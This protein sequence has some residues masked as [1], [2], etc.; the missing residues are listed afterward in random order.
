MKKRV[1]FDSSRLEEQ[2]LA[3]G[4]DILDV[5]AKLNSQLD[6]HIAVKGK[7]FDDS[8]LEE[9]FQKMVISTS[10]VVRLADEWFDLRQEDVLIGLI[11]PLSKKVRTSVLNYVPATKACFAN[12][13][14]YLTKNV[15]IQAF[16]M[17]DKYTRGLCAIVEILHRKRL[18]NSGLSFGSIDSMDTECILLIKIA[19]NLTTESRHIITLALEGDPMEILTSSESFLRAMDDFLDNISQYNLS[20]V[21]DQAKLLRAQHQAIISLSKDANSANDGSGQ[22]CIEDVGEKGA[23]ISQQVVDCTIELILYVIMYFQK[24]WQDLIDQQTS[25]ESTNEDSEP[26]SLGPRKPQKPARTKSGKDLKTSISHNR[27]KTRSVRL[28]YERK[29]GLQPSYMDTSAPI[30]IGG[31]AVTPK[32]TRTP[33][34]PVASIR[35]SGSMDEELATLPSR[36]NTVSSS[37]AYTHSAPEKKSPSSKKRRSEPAVQRSPGPI[38]NVQSKKRR[39]KRKS[40]TLRLRSTSD[41]KK[42]SAPSSPSDC[43]AVKYVEAPDEA[44]QKLNEL[45]DHPEQFLEKNKT[46]A[47]PT[48]HDDAEC[49]PNL[50]RG[51]GKKRRA[52]GKSLPSVPA[53]DMQYLRSAPSRTNSGSRGVPVFVSG[54]FY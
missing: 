29:Y 42:D 23:D 27:A 19:N 1:T 44:E 54:F 34:L 45:F 21:K 10:T 17:V 8:S 36:A 22:L 2:L 31:S 18:R 6:V 26:N 50:K 5:S 24:Q 52:Q 7:D 53:G 41:S 3:A 47:H 25:A 43:L 28:D 32:R 11:S 14:D 35:H 49:R 38:L 16:L 40:F 15:Q 30:Q 46:Q 39:K 51:S 20:Q 48:S 37:L 9:D 12:S 33:T 13:M 4:E